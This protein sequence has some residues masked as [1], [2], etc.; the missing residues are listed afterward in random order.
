[1]KIEKLSQ[2]PKMNKHFIRL[3]QIAQGIQTNVQVIWF[4]SLIDWSTTWEV[5]IS[6]RQTQKYKIQRQKLQVK[7]LKKEQWFQINYCY[8]C[9]FKLHT[10]WYFSCENTCLDSLSTGE[11]ERIV[12]SL[13]NNSSREQWSNKK[14]TN[15]LK[16]ENFF[17][18]CSC[19]LCLGDFVN[20]YTWAN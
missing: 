16:R 4:V 9:T 3:I 12:L 18:M 14:V 7:H 20:D 11:R 1:M 6:C 19:I 13:S 5:Q 10:I 8:S 15:W 17:L 2:A